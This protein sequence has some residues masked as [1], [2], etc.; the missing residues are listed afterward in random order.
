MTDNTKRFRGMY[1]WQWYY[2]DATSTYD[3]QVKIAKLVWAKK[4]RDVYGIH[5]DTDEAYEKMCRSL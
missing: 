4:N 3:A 2:V 5:L 1:K